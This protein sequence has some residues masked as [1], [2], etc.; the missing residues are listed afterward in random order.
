M[1]HIRVVSKCVRVGSC[2]ARQCTE[3][4][5]VSGSDISD[6][7]CMKYFVLLQLIK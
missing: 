3:D 4:L 6:P 5:G 1:N 2:Y 7:C